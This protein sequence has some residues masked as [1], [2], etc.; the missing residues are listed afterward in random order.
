MPYL[1]R[2]GMG[3]GKSGRE[4]EEE[5]PVVVGARTWNAVRLSWIDNR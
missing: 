4:L 5:L 2:T 3:K 1:M